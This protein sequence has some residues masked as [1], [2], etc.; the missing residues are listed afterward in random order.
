MTGKMICGIIERHIL[1]VVGWLVAVVGL[2][3]AV[4]IRYRT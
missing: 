3:V 4:Q 1:F 2:H